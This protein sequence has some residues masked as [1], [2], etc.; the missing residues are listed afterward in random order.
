MPGEYGNLCGRQM[1]RTVGGQ[2]GAEYLRRAMFKCD[3]AVDADGN[4]NAELALGVEGMSGDVVRWWGEV[5]TG[6][7][8]HGRGVFCFCVE[9]LLLVFGLAN[10]MVKMER[11]FSG[12]LVLTRVIHTPP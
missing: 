7:G 4:F 9:H 11:A 10:V 3:G 2:F 12:Y 6:G 5:A 1:E 8:A